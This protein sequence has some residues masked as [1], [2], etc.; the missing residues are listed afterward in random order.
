MI[1][2]HFIYTA[3]CEVSMGYNSME[4]LLTL[5]FVYSDFSSANFHAT[6]LIYHHHHY[7]AVQECF[8]KLKHPE[9]NRN[10]QQGY[11]ETILSVT[12]LDS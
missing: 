9:Y 8:R 7:C 3:L 12:R 2:K 1:P 4:P 10:S 11:I 6:Y 5:P